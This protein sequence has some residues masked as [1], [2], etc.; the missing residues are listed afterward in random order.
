MG[1]CGRCLRRRAADWARP[2]ET[3]TEQAWCLTMV[4]NVMVT[5]TTEYYR[6]AVASMHAASRRI[7][8]EILA[9]IAP[10]PSEDINIVGGIEV[11][12]ELAQLGPTCY[13]S[14]PVSDTLF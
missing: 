10:A 4:T 6:L 13:R 3:Q 9:H 14:P 12:S 8:D 2:L 7:D 5:W 11:K 1:R